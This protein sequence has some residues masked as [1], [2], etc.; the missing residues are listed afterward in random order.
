QILCEAG[1]LPGALVRNRSLRFVCDR[2]WLKVENKKTIFTSRF[3]EVDVIRLPIAHGDGCYYADEATLGQ[4]EKEGRVVFRYVNR[5]GVADVA[6]N[7]NGSCNNIAGILNEKG[8][9]LGLMPHPER[10]VF[11]NLGLTYGRLIFNSIVDYFLSDE[12]RWS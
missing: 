2:V 12:Y 4:L 11:E 9:V 5:D 7:P 3:G 1:L 6:S 10:A 8:N